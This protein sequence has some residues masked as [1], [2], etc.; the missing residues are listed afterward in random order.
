MGKRIICLNCQET[1][2][3][4]DVT[5]PRCLGTGLLKEGDTCT[6]CGGSGEV[7]I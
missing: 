1:G 2:F 5:C 6:R 3:T 7:E 4:A